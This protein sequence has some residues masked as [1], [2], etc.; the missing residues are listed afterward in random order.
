M[1]P[2]LLDANL[3]QDPDGGRLGFTSV[4]SRQENRKLIPPETGDEIRGPDT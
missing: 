2:I 3:V 4:C 1:N